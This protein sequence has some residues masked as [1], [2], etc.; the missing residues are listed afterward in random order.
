VVRRFAAGERGS[1]L[2]IYIG[3]VIAVL[4]CWGAGV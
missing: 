1:M 4:A 3:S 2:V